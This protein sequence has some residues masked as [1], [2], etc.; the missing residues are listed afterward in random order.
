MFYL[1][2]KMIPIFSEVANFTKTMD[3][4]RPVTA[5]IATPIG[6]ERAVSVIYLE[7]KIIY[8]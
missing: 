5:A 4:H 6:S 3:P 7:W 1:K 2:N 8:F